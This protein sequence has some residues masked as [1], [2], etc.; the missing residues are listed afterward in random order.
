MRELNI[1]ITRK[2]LTESIKEIF[3]KEILRCLN[4]CEILYLIK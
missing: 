2:S 1:K 4:K 3:K